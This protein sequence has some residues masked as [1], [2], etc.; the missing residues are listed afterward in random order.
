MRDVPEALAARID[1][2]AARLCHAWIVTLRDTERLGFSDHD[3]PV[4]I[5]AIECQPACG[6]TAGAA[7][8]ELGL[9]AGQAAVSGVLDVQGVALDDLLAGRWDGARVEVW[10]LDW[11]EPAL[12]VRIGIGDVAR[13][14]VTD[15]RLTLELEGPIARLD[16]V[17]GRSFSRLCDATLGDARCGVD[18]AAVPGLTCDKRFETCRARFQNAANFRGFPDMPGDDFLFARPETEGRHDGGS[19]R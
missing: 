12:R 15:D 5:D 6:W 11:D 9:D 7:H 17:V 10:R 1:S 3:E 16:Q 19:R 2:G 4:T 18:V 13:V 14:V 8:Q